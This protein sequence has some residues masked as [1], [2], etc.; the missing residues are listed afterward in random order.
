[1]AG[2]TSLPSLGIY[3]GSKFAVEGLSEAVRSEME[4]YGVQVMIVEPGPFNTEWIGKNAVWVEQT[5]HYPKVWEA[6]DMM[7]GAYADR[8]VVGD[9]DRAAEAIVTCVTSGNPPF[10]LALHEM[11]VKSTREKLKVVAADLDRMEPISGSVH[12][13]F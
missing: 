8:T 2:E 9:P 12:Y 10:R 4:P 13:S 7:K 11:S 1:M 5:D 3:S 6:V